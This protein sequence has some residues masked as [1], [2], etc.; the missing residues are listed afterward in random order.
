MNRCNWCDGKATIQWQTSDG[1]TWV[2]THCRNVILRSGNRPKRH[3]Q[4]AGLRQLYLNFETPNEKGP[5]ALQKQPGPKG[6]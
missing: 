5:E 1:T 4:Q 3:K 6:I 2:C